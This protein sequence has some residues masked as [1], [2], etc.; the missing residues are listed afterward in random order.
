M[1]DNLLQVVWVSRSIS[2]Y[3]K[4]V[5]YCSS[6]SFCCILCVRDSR[7]ALPRV[8]CCRF[9]GVG[10][11]CIRA[12][13]G[14]GACCR[15]PRGAGPGGGAVPVRRVHAVEVRESESGEGDER[16]DRRMVVAQGHTYVPMQWCRLAYF[17][18]LYGVV[19]GARQMRQKTGVPRSH[20]LKCEGGRV[21]SSL[22]LLF[23]TA[24]L[25]RNE[26]VSFCPFVGFFFSFDPTI[27]P[28]VCST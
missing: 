10:P 27:V 8:A 22:L 11:R 6:L 15:Q 20:K 25:R 19:F 26:L 5:Y 2:W 4:Y 24:V 3:T 23:T 28:H 18:F 13:G 14:G 16:H 17:F 1:C 9:Q 7:A 12:R 21:G